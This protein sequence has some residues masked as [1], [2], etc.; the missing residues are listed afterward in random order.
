MTYRIGKSFTFDAAHHLHGLAEGHKCSRQHGHTYTVDLVLAADEVTGP[1][2]VTDF[3]DL[4]PFGSYLEK[5]L[6][7]RDLNT[8]LPFQPTSERLARHLAEWFTEHLGARVG[9]RLESVRVSET[10]TS[11]AEYRPPRREAALP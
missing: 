2:F 5:V 4:A 9:G 3:G 11:W 7:H 6:D 8:L 10:P 1:G